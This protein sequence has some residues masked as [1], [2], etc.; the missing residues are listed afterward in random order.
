MNTNSETTTSYVPVNQSATSTISAPVSQPI[1]QNPKKSNSCLVISVVGCALL[2]LLCC[3]C[4]LV[5][6][7]A[8]SYLVDRLPNFIDHN[9]Q[10]KPDSTYTSASNVGKT[11]KS[12]EALL[13][14]RVENARNKAK[15]EGKDVY[16]V[17]ITQEELFSIAS[18]SKD[19]FIKKLVDMSSLKLTEGNMEIKIDV[20]RLIQY[21]NEEQ[22]KIGSSE[23]GDPEKFEGMF[24]TIKLSSVDGKIKLTKISSGNLLLDIFI[25][26]IPMDQYNQILNEELLKQIGSVVKEI[27]FEEGRVV[28]VAYTQE[29]F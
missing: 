15:A 12:D 5:G 6:F 2:L 10:V 17:V 11:I 1:V 14:E 18:L 19:E 29:S 8:P 16:E 4:A 25:G 7:V 20:K 22:N 21:L 3:G 27:K 23:I 24:Y 28:I 26:N 9:A 13:N